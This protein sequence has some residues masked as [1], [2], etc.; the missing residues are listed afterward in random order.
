VD[1]QPILFCATPGSHWPDNTVVSTAIDELAGKLEQPRLEQSL[2]LGYVSPADCLADWAAR[3]PMEQ[4]PDDADAALLLESWSSAARLF[5]DLQRRHGPRCRLLHLG[6]LR[7]PD[8]AQ[9]AGEADQPGAEWAA[10]ASAENAGASLDAG[11]EPLLWR[12]PELADLYADLEGCADLRGRSAELTPMPMGRAH[13]AFARA[14]LLNWHERRRE[15]HQHALEIGQLLA[16][17]SQLEQE[18]IQLSEVVTEC[19]RQAQEALLDLHTANA[20]VARLRGQLT[21]R[22]EELVA[23][24]ERSEGVLEQLEQTQVDLE[25]T[26]QDRQAQH[27]LNEA[28]AAAI[29]EAAQL[30]RRLAALRGMPTEQPS[31]SV[32]VMALL[33]GYRHSLKRAE[34]LLGSDD[35]VG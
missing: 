1:Q 15:Q 12:H 26:Y 27:Q 34:R 20:E 19:Q 17:I 18:R 16:T 13:P 3:L 6:R 5:L 11:L 8:W 30:L 21:H 7:R 4:A 9:L 28:Q 25:L 22:E 24:R 33:E 23:A 14:S 2:W 29:G 35:R 32:Q 10:E 31:T